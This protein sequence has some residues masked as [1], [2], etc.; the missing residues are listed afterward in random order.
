VFAAD[1][2]VHL[3]QRVT[4]TPAGLNP[5]RDGAE[6]AELKGHTD[7]ALAE[8][9]NGQ[10]GY[11]PKDLA[12]IA[13]NPNMADTIKGNILDGRVKDLAGNNPAL[14]DVYPNPAGYPGPDFVNGGTRTDIGWYDLTT[15]R[16]WGQHMFDYGPNYGP[17]IGIPWK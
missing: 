9:E 1:V 13:E 10:L 17:G 7:Q 11:S 5:P 15:G 8:W 12:R 6:T 14:S 4:T 16:M 3:L 2:D